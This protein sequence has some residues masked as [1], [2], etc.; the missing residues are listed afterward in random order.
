[1]SSVNDVLR[2]KSNGDEVF[3]IG[4]DETVYE[5]VHRLAERGIG[6]L[7]VLEDEELV[8]IVSERD[9]ARKIILRGRASKDT[10]VREIMTAEVITIGRQTRIEECMAIMT[11]KR[12]RHLP[13]IESG[14]VIGMV[15]IGDV[16]RRII[17]EQEEYIHHLENYI[18]NTV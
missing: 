3:S 6:A 15:S 4:P 13:V 12:I 9:Y 8:G 1:M 5:A 10:K 18:G 7:V 14:R 2:G 17:S 16:V 11:N